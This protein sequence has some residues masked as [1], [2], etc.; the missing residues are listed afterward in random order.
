MK[1]LQQQHTDMVLQM[2]ARIEELETENNMLKHTLSDVL[3]DLP[4]N[5]DWLDPNLE[6]LMRQLIKP[7]ETE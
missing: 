7:P 6:R 3:G 1:T 2:Q 4:S 5:R